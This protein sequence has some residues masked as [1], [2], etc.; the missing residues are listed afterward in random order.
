MNIGKCHG[1]PKSDVGGEKGFYVG[2][3]LVG[4]YWIYVP[5]TWIKGFF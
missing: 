4:L 5:A 2:E 3:S 1:R